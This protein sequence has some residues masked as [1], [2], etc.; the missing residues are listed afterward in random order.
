MLTPTISTSATSQ[1]A[2]GGEDAVEDLRIALEVKGGQF[3]RFEHFRQ[4]VRQHLLVTDARKDFR[5]VVGE[6]KG[7]EVAQDNDVGGVFRS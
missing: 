4:Q 2:I 1:E 7:V 5:E 6:F 3:V